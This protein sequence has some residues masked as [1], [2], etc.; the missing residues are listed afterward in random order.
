MNIFQ[1]NFFFFKNS[2]EFCNFT[3]IKSLSISRL[4]YYNIKET[5]ARAFHTELD[6]VHLP[7][8]NSY[9]G[10]EDDNYKDDNY[11]EHV[12]NGIVINL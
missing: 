5:L 9:H 1:E 12:D 11:H 7:F 2:K 4:L 6:R 3:H 8:K 10:K